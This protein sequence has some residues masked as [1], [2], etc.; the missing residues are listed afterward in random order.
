MFHF[1]KALG[2]NEYES[3]QLSTLG[4]L[5]DIGKISIPSNILEKN[6]ALNAFE[7]SVIELHPQIG[8]QLIDTIQHPFTEIAKKSNS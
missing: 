1:G 3:R 6:G 2:Y 5:H 8:Y 4:N 7:R